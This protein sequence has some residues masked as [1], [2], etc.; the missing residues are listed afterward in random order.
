MK[1]GRRECQRNGRRER[2]REGCTGWVRRLTA[3][4]FSRQTRGLFVPLSIL[5]GLLFPTF[6]P[7]VP[8]FSILPTLPSGFLPHSFLHSHP[9]TSSLYL[10]RFI[11]IRLRRTL[12]FP[13]LHHPLLVCVHLFRMLSSFLVART[14]GLHALFR[15][16]VDISVYVY[17]Y[18]DV[19][20]YANR[21][22]RMRET[23]TRMKNVHLVQ[24]IYRFS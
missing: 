13:L 24:R 17:I 14:F 21:D 20:V 2:E 12:S 9:E 1:E 5:S 4:D 11:S 16:C 22:T 18:I 7:P 8:S 19:K 6:P 23:H 3:I 15:T 10:P